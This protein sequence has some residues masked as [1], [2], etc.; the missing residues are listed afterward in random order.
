MKIDSNELETKSGGAP[1]PAPS[2]PTAR[3]VAK[4]IVVL[5]VGLALGVGATWLAMHK[6][7]VANLDASKA[8]D[9]PLYQCPMHPTITSDHPGD[10]PIC[11]MKLVLVPRAATGSSTPGE[12]KVAFYRSIDVLSVPTDFEEPKGLSI[13]EAWANGVPVVQ[14][15]TGAFPE[16]VGADGGLL[17]PHRDR[18]AGHAGRHDHDRGHDH[19]EDRE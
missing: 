16:L 17:V 15:A 10:C 12:R 6:S 3:L 18:Y 1:K 13:L 9:Q 8:A 14:P 2:G 4:S 11:G 7:G 19:H 5:V